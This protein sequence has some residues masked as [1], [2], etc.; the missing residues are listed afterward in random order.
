VIASAAVFLTRSSLNEQFTLMID[1]STVLGTLVYLYCCVCL[2][3]ISGRAATVRGRWAARICAVLGG[4]FCAGV[5]LGSGKTLLITSLVFIA[6]TI[7]LW[8]IYLLGQ[9]IAAAR[10]ETVGEA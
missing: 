10:L 2:A 7:P 9:K 4:L 1:V 8:A 6:A 5:I 3:R